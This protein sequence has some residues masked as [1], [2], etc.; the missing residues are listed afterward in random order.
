MR[1][2]AN[3]KHGK[4]AFTF[5][6]GTVFEGVFVH[7]R[8]ADGIV[9][10]ATEMPA[11]LTGTTDDDAHRV[12]NLLVRHDTRVRQIYWYYTQLGC[13]QEVSYSSYV[14]ARLHNRAT[15]RLSNAFECLLQAPRLF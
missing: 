4:G 13:D 8:M 6:D 10:A 7:D 11:H 3:K 2:Q 14:H 5:E 9:L 15:I 1:V 12:Q